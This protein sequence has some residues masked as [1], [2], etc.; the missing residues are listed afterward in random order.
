MPLSC[1]PRERGD[2]YAAASRFCTQANGFISQ[3]TAVVMGPCVRRDDEL[4]V[5]ISK[6]PKIHTVIASEAKQ[7]IRPRGSKRGLLRSARNDVEAH[8]R[9]G[10]TPAH[11]RD[12]SRPSHAQKSTAS[13]NRGRGECRVPVAP[14]ASRA[15]KTKHTSVVTARF[16]GETRH[17]RTRMVLTVSFALS[18][19]TG[20]SCHRRL[21]KIA[22][23][24]LDTSVGASGPHDFAVRACAARLAPPPRPPHPAPN[25]RD[26]R[27]TPLM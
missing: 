23:A 12:A 2:P 26:D 24:K 19:V 27:E 15:K 5:Q 25:V 1:R 9:Q 17:S 14:A 10:H 18:S 11:S 6:Q 21:A 8:G 16:T 7:S 4:R 13:E 20:L 22:S 3:W